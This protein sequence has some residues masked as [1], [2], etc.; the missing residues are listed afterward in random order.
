MHKMNKCYNCL[1]SLSAHQSYEISYKQIIESFK[2]HHWKSVADSKVHQPNQLTLIPD[3]HHHMENEDEL[4]KKAHKLT[5]ITDPVPNIIRNS[6]KSGITRQEYMKAIKNPVFINNKTIVCLDCFMLITQTFLLDPDA[7]QDKS[8]IGIGEEDKLQEK[9]KFL[10]RRPLDPSYQHYLES[11][12]RKT[13]ELQKKMESPRSAHHFKSE[14]VEETK[15]QIKERENLIASLISNPLSKGRRLKYKSD[16]PLL[17][18]PGSNRSLATPY[19]TKDNT[20]SSTK[21]HSR[22]SSLDTLGKLSTM[23]H[24]KEDIESN[25]ANFY[26]G[27]NLPLLSKLYSVTNSRVTSPTTQLPKSIPNHVFRSF[28]KGKLPSEEERDQF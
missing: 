23:A 5:A 16:L 18:H 8:S 10:G 2:I 6:F 24:P 17:E 9:S 14:E 3:I 27:R 12:T 20:I 21:H 26:A 15:T 28:S 13:I 19:V 22:I 4:E 25:S 7:K 1:K 11:Q